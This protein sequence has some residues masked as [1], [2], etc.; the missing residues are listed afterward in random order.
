MIKQGLQKEIVARLSAK[1]PHKVILFGSRASGHFEEG[2]DV[3]L[4][5]VLDKEG[6][7]RTFRE[8]TENFLEISRLL[9]DLNKRIAMDLI[10]MTRTQWDNF[11]KFDS[12][13][14]REVQ[15]K[16]MPLI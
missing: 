2:S 9:R 1:K 12:G 5:I 8:K 6:V 11:V 3:D 16:G 7:P 4:L 14:S 15:E 10:V 13:F